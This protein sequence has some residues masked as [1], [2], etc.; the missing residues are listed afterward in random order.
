[1]LTDVNAKALRMARINAAFAGIEIETV[2]T[3]GLQGAPGPWDLILANPPYI[4]DAAGRDYRDGGELHGAQMSLD[5]AGEAMARLAPGGRFVLYTGSAIV[6]GA[7][8]LLERL[9]PAAAAAGCELD[10]RELDPDVFGE[11]LE[12]PG[13][14]DVERIAVVAATLTRPS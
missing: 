4:L 13:Y 9:A 14:A 7:D 11:E 12:Q 6:G 5:W 3:E 8:P 10:Y 1:M 2:Q